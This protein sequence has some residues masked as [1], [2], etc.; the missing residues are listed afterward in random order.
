MLRSL[1]DGVESVTLVRKWSWK[2]LK[3]LTLTIP[4]Q[5]CRRAGEGEGPHPRKTKEAIMKL[6]RLASC[7]QADRAP[8]VADIAQVIGDGRCHLR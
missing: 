8:V 2:I 7:S 5:S 6:D 1:A 3:R 4:T